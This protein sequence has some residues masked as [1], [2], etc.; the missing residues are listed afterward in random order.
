METATSRPLTSRTRVALAIARAV[1]AGRGDK[2]LTPT[3]VALGIFREGAN[4]A[5][6]ALYNRGLAPKAFHSIARQ[7]E[8]RLGT[9][10]GKTAPREVVVDLTPGEKSILELGDREAELL[11][12]EYLGTEHILLGLLRSSNNDAALILLQNGVSLDSFE[13]GLSAVRRGELPGDN[14]TAL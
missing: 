11:N 8:D 12:D 5:L 10:P 1:A 3:H 9:P 6:G 2:D 14:A 4:P 7:L 13:E